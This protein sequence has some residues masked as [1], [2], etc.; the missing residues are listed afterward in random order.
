MHAPAAARARARPVRSSTAR[1]SGPRA[2][3]NGRLPSSRPRRR[4]SASRSAGGRWR[5]SI[6]GSS[7]GAGGMDHLHRLAVHLR[8]DGAQRLVAARHLREAA[9]QHR[10]VEIPLQPRAARQVVGRRARLELVQE[11][12][13]L[14]REGEREIRLPRQAARS[15]APSLAAR[16]AAPPPPRRPGPPRSAP[17]TGAAA[18]ARRR[19]PS[20]SARRPAWPAASG[21]RGRRSC[22]GTPTRSTLSTSA[23]IPASS[24]STGPCGGH[25][26]LPP[27]AVASGA[28]SALRS[29]LPLG[30][31]GSASSAT[32]AD[33]HHV[34]RQ[35]APQ[36]LP[37]LAR[38]QVRAARRDRPPGA[39]RR[40][41]RGPPRRP[42]DTDGWR[43][44]AA[45]ISPSSMRKPRTFT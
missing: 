12:H 10:S 11:P 20:G 27:S 5:R 21:R 6:S 15:A 23:Q 32:K 42:R 7:K 18:A 45:S 44:R 17:R 43:S 34:L 41:P 31:S 22:P 25:P 9:R 36:G 38:R 2:R 19:G 37:E 33:G 24:S 35:A 39:C 8:E 26:A 13:P 40:R 30:V 1:S 14:L 16:L 28:G 29:T 3:S 4:S